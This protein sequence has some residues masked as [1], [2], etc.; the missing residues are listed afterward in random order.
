LLS[1]EKTSIDELGEDE[2]SLQYE[3]YLE[4]KQQKAKLDRAVS[5]DANQDDEEYTGLLFAKTF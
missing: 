1:L 3:E 2:F 4:V 5:P